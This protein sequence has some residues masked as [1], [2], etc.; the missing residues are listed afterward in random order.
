MI[1]NRNRLVTSP[2]REIA[3]DCIEAAI[4]A[5]APEIATRSGVTVDG[6]TLSIGDA[7]YDLEA[8]E[9]V[10]VVGGG[11]AAGG[12]SQTLE[13]MLGDRITDGLIVTKQPAEIEYVRTVV[14]D[15]PLPSQRNVEATAELLELV[16]TADEETLV[17]FVLTGG[18]SALLTA[19]AGKVTLAE[20]RETTELLLEGGVPIEEINAVRKHLSVSK[21]G[22]LAREAAPAT[23]VGLLLSDVVGNDLSTIGSGPSVPDDTTYADA[24]TVF[25]QYDLDPPDPVRNHLTDGTGGE[26]RETPLSDDPVF[27]RVQNALL[28]DN[29]MAL[30][31]ARDSISDTEYK[32][33]VLSSRLRG[34]A[35]EVAKA[36]IAIAEEIAATGTPIEPPAVLIAGGETTA[37]VSGKGGQGGP[38]QEFVLSAAL[39]RVDDVVVAAVDSDGEDGST[40]AAGAIADGTTV[41]GEIE[42]AQAHLNANDAGTYLS[43]INATIETGATGTNVNDILV[44]VVQESAT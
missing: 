19:P 23:V 27:G 13:S 36:G 29:K 14:G 34:E 35:S 42:R 8:Y 10:L 33:L 9:D 22:Q 2:E 28:G 31:A 11:K 3:L 30:D 24:L 7:T 41:N 25:E 40:D 44:L 5:A 12:V 43:E 16:R 17:L 18:A 37:S 4:E 38:N 6:D 32:P 39:E 20:L 1:S 21:G 15:H 26:L